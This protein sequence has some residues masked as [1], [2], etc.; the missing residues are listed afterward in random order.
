MAKQ[1]TPIRKDRK[2]NPE[3]TRAAILHAAL[4]EFSEV[5]HSGA[6]VDRIAAIDSVAVIYD[7]VL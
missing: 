5:G 6:R 7:V 3:V 1:V 2:R 4:E